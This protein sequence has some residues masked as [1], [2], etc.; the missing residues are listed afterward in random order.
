M[1]KHCATTSQGILC[2]VSIK[3]RHGSPWLAHPKGSFSLNEPHCRPGSG[4]HSLSHW[5][6]AIYHRLIGTWYI[7]DVTPCGRFVI[8][9]ADFGLIVSTE[10]LAGI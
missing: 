6:V 10:V 9:V 2:V 8:Y 3:G 5:V 4:T 1:P 7:S